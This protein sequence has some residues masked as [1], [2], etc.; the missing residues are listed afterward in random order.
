MKKATPDLALTSDVLTFAYLGEFQM[1]PLVGVLA[2]AEQL[3]TL[4]LW[5]IARSHSQLALK[6]H[7]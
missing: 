4:P 1:G 3:P 2:P 7:L 6:A 5:A